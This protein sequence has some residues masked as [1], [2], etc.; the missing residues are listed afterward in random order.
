MAEPSARWLLMVDGAARG[1]P[2]DA[3][4]GA[5]IYDENGVVVKELSRYL[6]RAT[7]NVAEYEGLLIGLEPLIEP[8]ERTSLCKV[9]RNLGLAS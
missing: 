5:A 6:G 4:C 2:G 7:N 1:N 8:I 9:I 3:G